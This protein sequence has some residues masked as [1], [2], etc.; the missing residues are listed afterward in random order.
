MSCEFT[1]YNE[2]R[3]EKSVWVDKEDF[4][5]YID[6]DRGNYRCVHN[7]ILKVIKKNNW[8][9]MDTIIVECCCEKYIFRGGHIDDEYYEILY[10]EP[11]Y[12]DMC[13]NVA[14]AV[15]PNLTDT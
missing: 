13:H 9:I 8:D 3:N 10:N 1:Y 14:E 6:I 5:L 4:R 12:C 7:T 15:I 2:T 11:C